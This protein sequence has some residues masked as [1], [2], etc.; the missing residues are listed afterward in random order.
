MIHCIILNVSSILK[1]TGVS[2]IQINEP[3]NISKHTDAL[4]C[5]LEDVPSLVPVGVM[6]LNPLSIDENVLLVCIKLTNVIILLL[7]I[8]RRC[9]LKH[10]LPTG[11][12][13]IG[14]KPGT[15]QV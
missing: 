14:A 11:E 7:S 5:F 3:E 2:N 15:S 6:Y 13:I 4:N 10:W 8:G 12:E 9:N 1:T